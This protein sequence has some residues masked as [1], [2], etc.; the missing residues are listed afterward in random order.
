LGRNSRGDD[1]VHATIDEEIFVRTGWPKL[2]K[3]LSEI[4]EMKEQNEKLLV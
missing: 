4:L 2:K 1:G 3:A